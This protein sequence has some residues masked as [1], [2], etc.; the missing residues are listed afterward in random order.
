MNNLKEI[1]FEIKQHQQRLAI[2]AQQKR[3]LQQ[4]PS[5]VNTVIIN[6]L[7]AKTL[8]MTALNVSVEFRDTIERLSQYLF[9]FLKQGLRTVPLDNHPNMTNSNTMSPPTSPI[10]ERPITS[11]STSLSLTYSQYTQAWNLIEATIS[12]NIGSEMQGANSQLFHLPKE[13]YVNMF[14]EINNYANNTNQTY[15][16][17][18]GI[19]TSQ[20][21][22]K[23]HFMV[24]LK[25]MKFKFQLFIVNLL[26]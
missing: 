14:Q 10:H 13:A 24:M 25:S 21:R 16:I 6:S 22:R 8:D 9:D 15:L 12:L 11:D 18:S 19:N 23:H 17:D 7:E 20:L 26:K 1:L 2:L 5:K 3:E 4:S